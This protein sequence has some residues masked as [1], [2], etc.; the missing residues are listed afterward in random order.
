M[1]RLMSQRCERARAAVSLELD[2]GL[3]PVELAFLRR[4]LARCPRCSEFR[5]ECAAF[6][7]ALRAAPLEPVTRS[8]VVGTRSRRRRRGGIQRV[9]VAAAGIATLAFAYG[10]THVDHV[11]SYEAPSSARPAYLDSTDFELGLLRPAR[12]SRSASDRVP[13]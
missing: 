6:T 4:H 11:R 8:V 7:G 1:G 3:S 9:A 13:I 10:A 2:D 12:A 5:A